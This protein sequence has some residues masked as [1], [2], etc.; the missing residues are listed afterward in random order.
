M[1]S[2]GNF[3]LLCL[4]NPLLDI[5]GVGDEKLLEKYGLKAN[6]AIL[7]EEKHLGL[8]DDL[9]KNYKA[10]L[11]AGGAAQNSARGAQYIL[12]ADST[13]YIGCIGRDKYGEHLEEICAQAGVKT[14]YRYDEET[15][16]GRCGVV[17]TGHNRS[18]CTDLAAANKYQL[19][20]LKQPEVWKLVENAKFLY[21]GGYHLTVCVPAIL[22][23]AEEAAAK[24][25]LFILNLSAPFIPQFF[26]DQ[27]DQVLPYVDI[28]IGNETE[29]GA[30]AESHRL[31]SKD[32]KEVAKSIVQLPKKNSK[33][34]RTVVFT[35]GTDP[36]V[37]VVAK[38]SGDFEIKETPVHAIGQELINDTNGAGDAFAGGFLAGIVRGKPLETAIDMGQWLARLSIQQLGPSYPFPKQ[39]YG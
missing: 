4:E 22:A 35:Q 5:Q 20:H 28:L 24:D 32:V 21:V 19:D 12:P 18:L 39:T 25:K 31:F 13:V 17:I 37:S 2:K 15:P 3:E 10:V 36:T 23:L 7:A 38:D 30:Y 29:A 9:I 16:T 33:K 26:K 6:D 1:A 34:P 27:L 14:A 11:I 8:Y